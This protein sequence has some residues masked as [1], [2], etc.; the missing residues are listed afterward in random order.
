MILP[1][2]PDPINRLLDRLTLLFDRRQADL[3]EPLF[4]GELFAHG[5]RTATAWFRL[6]DVGD[7]FRRA[8]TVLGSLGRYHLETGASV[9]FSDLCK[10]I[11]PGPRWLFALDDTPTPRYG[12][13]V[14]GAGRHHNPTPGPAQQKFLY[15]HIWVTTAWVVRH[16]QWDT[17][18][19]PLLADLYIRDKDLPKID[20]DRRPPFQTKLQQAAGQIRWIAQQVG[21][22]AKPVW[23]VVDGFYAKRP[24]LKEAQA[25]G[26]VVVGRLRW[27]AALRDLPP[28]PPPP[29]QRRGQGRP[30]K[31]GRRRLSLAKRANHR[32]GWQQVNCFQYQ[33]EVTKT[34]K[35]FLAT[36]RPA[37]GVI[38][39]VIV[40]EE[41]SWRA[42]F[43]TEAS[44]SVQDILEAAAGR[45]AIEQTFKEVKEIEGAGQQ[46]LRY[47]RANA[48]AF[49]WCLWGYSAV[50]WWAWDKPFAELVNRSSSPWDE[51]DRRP[52]HANRRR[53]LERQ[54]L[55]GE[56]WRR[57]GEEAC[58][59]EIQEIVTML[60]DKV[61]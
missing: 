34:V 14:E 21:N 50:E 11:D 54:V 37:G 24:V 28:P 52:S 9:L 25:Q 4:L 3:I 2:P 18:A 19:L 7:Q 55:E 8:Y 17:L 39:V 16:P 23:V 43:C 5:T 1:Q 57:W 46:Q 35:T 13:C 33:E 31:Y 60:L 47:W 36:W 26:V 40:R 6:A 20:A 45:T 27:D 44:A 59:A 41:D 42:Y 22:T 12:P 56:F 61:A 53:A 15:G 38:R 30:R 58:P 32:E 49:H 10:T 51:A 29:G 48:G